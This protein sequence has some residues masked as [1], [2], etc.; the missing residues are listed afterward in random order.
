ML[1]TN[2]SAE[3][4]ASPGRSTPPKHANIQYNFCKNPVCS[5]FGVTPPESFKRGILGSYAIIYSGRAFPLLKCN[6]CGETPPMK[7]N[8]GI[9]EEIK[10]LIAYL[11]PVPQSTCSTDDCVNQ[12]ISIGTK[13]VYY[14]FMCASLKTG[15]SM[16]NLNAC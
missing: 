10:R 2:S 6:L 3:S 9:H 14:N 11:E 7:S 1:K 5:N 15:R 8:V 12:H 13:G 4:S 16:R